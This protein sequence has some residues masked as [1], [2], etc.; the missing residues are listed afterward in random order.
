MKKEVWHGPNTARFIY[1]SYKDTPY[2]SLIIF[3]FLLLISLLLI[4]N[5]VIP[6]TQNW[7]SLREEAIATQARVDTLKKN[8]SYMS[9]INKTSLENNR[10]TVIRALPVEKDFESIINA[11]TASSALSGVSIDDFSFALGPI[12]S[13]SG[14]ML[15]KNNGLD[16]ITI[17]LSLGGNIGN[18]K[19]FIAG[20]EEKMPI[21]EIVS[22]ETG[23]DG[24]TI[25]LLFYSK[26]Y[27]PVNILYTD[28]IQ[29]VSAANTTLLGKLSSWSKGI[30]SS[31]EET[32]PAPSA[33]IPLF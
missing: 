22:A 6:Q 30:M 20:I 27:R 12:A 4:L 15:K 18:I 7:F 28:P 10:Q 23:K 25:S 3:S 2:F 1:L 33:D 14:A 29:P 24:T 17:T 31:S 13:S 16:M 21:S 9:G 19:N 32:P 11:V 5:I 26:P 8:I